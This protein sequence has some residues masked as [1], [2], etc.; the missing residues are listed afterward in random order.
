MNRTLRRGC[1]GLC[2]SWLQVTADCVDEDSH[3]T[4]KLVLSSAD[5]LDDREAGRRTF[6]A[7]AEEPSNPQQQLFARVVAHEVEA[8][9]GDTAEPRWLQ[10]N[11]ARPSRS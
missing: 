5:S 9:G 6:I 7:A 1:L 3:D 11:P 10:W 4:M 2:T 8:R